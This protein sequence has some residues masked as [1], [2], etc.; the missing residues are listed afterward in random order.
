MLAAFEP[1]LNTL[2]GSRGTELILAHCNAL[3]RSE[4]QLPPAAERLEL[5]LGPLAQ[6][7]VFAL[8]GAQSGAQSRRSSSSP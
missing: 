8:S 6:L 3:G 1:A 7:L 5:E 4:N 2:P